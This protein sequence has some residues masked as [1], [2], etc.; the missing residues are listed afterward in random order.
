VATAHR[1]SRVRRQN[2]EPDSG[3]LQDRS[4]LTFARLGVLLQDLAIGSE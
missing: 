2:R 1:G 3:C 4:P